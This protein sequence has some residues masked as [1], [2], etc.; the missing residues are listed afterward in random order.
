MFIDSIFLEEIISSLVLLFQAGIISN[1]IAPA[2][3]QKKT[4]QVV[5]IESSG[6]T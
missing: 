5:G 2:C 1:I 3:Q 4:Q 6:L